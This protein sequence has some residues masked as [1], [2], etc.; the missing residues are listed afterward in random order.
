M[1]SKLFDTGMVQKIADFYN[2]NV[3]D[4]T[5]FEGIKETSAKK[6]LDNLFR[7]KQIPLA[8]FIAGFDIENIG[9]QLVQRVVDAG[10]DTLEDIKDASVYELSK[11]DG[12]A[13]TNAHYLLDGV[14]T[15]YQDMLDVLNTNK[16]KI[17]GKEM[18]GKLEGLS[19]CFTGKLETRA[20][21][22]ENNIGTRIP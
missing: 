7:V 17:K 4:L 9:E 5:K 15:L 14:N 11:I 12:F 19:F 3:S 13:E 21:G 16:I 10:F 2:L 22:I 6:A 20:A 18:G 8:T 1:L